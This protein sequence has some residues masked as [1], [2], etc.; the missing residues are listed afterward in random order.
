MPGFLYAVFIKLSNYPFSSEKRMTRDITSQREVLSYHIAEEKG[1][2]G[3]VPSKAPV[4][5]C[6]QDNEEKRGSRYSADAL[7][8]LRARN[9]VG[10][11]AG[12]R[13]TERL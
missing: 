11:Y 10:K 5:D 4:P 12:D 6:C 1:D 7:P 8:C 2:H 3:P 9:T 13:K